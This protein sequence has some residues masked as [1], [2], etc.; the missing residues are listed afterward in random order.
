MLLAFEA[1]I[2][3]TELK[4]RIKSGKTSIFK[5][6]TKMFALMLMVSLQCLTSIH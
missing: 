1:K 6:K 4:N 3:E 2:M 5:K